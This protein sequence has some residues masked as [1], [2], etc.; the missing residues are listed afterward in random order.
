MCN[1]FGVPVS[2]SK[3]ARIAYIRSVL[4][5]LSEYNIPWC[6]YTNANGCWTPVIADTNVKRGG[7]ELPADGSLVRKDGFW[8]DMAMLE[9]LK[10]YMK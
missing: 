6:I 9:L 2:L 5:L 1:E 10:E 7:T 8:Y 3:K 4:E